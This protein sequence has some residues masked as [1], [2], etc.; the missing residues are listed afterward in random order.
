MG[1]AIGRAPIQLRDKNTGLVV[2]TTA[3]ERDGEFFMNKD[4]VSGE[5]L[6]SVSSPGFTPV[7]LPLTLDRGGLCRVPLHIEMGVLGACGKVEDKG[8]GN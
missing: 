7:R 4:I 5:Y 2:A 8:V 3:T 6:L 1:A